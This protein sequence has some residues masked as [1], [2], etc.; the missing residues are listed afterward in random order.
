MISR[1]L[2]IM[3]DFCDQLSLFRKCDCEVSL[4]TLPEFLSDVAF[5]ESR[6]ALTS[7]GAK[8]LKV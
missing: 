2:G 6:N 7:G 8:R 3:C 1:A 4:L 5:L